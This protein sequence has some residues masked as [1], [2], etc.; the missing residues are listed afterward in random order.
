MSREQIL[1]WYGLIV[2][3]VAWLWL[4]TLPTSP[5]DPL[6]VLLFAVLAFAVDLLA[7]RTPPADVHSLAPLVLITASLALGPVNAAWVA[8]IEGLLSGIVILLLTN[9][10]RTSSSLLGRPLCAQ[11]AHEKHANDSCGSQARER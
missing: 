5:V 4:L 11:I 1:T 7:F 2:G 10:P 9:R 8:A 3:V 6:Y